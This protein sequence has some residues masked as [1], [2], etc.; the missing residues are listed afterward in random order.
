MGLF[1][2]IKNMF[3]GEK[4]ESKAEIK[5]TETYVDGLEKSRKEFVSKLSLLGIK[6]TK[7]INI[8]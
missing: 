7:I 4:E 6:Y 8:S 3:S 2:K 1:S 5:E